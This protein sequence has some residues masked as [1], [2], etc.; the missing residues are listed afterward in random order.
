MS[1]TSIFLEVMLFKFQGRQ[2]SVEIEA[3]GELRGRHS[4]MQG[5]TTSK[6]GGQKRRLKLVIDTVDVCEIGELSCGGDVALR[7]AHGQA[8]ASFNS[9]VN[10][11]WGLAT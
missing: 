8:Q 9:E 7:Y 5:R 6:P 11:G 10:A 2:S 3:A 1:E 4:L